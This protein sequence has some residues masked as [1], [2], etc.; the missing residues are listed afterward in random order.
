MAT[1][2][3]ALACGFENSGKLC[4]G[5]QADLILLDV[6]C[7]HAQP[8]SDPYVHVAYSA[9]GSDVVLTMA[10]GRILYENGEYLTLDKEKIMAEAKLASQ[11][12]GVIK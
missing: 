2:Q 10:A 4:L 9:Q 5:A 11:K 7:P 8:M 6:S 1:R 3:S 12:L